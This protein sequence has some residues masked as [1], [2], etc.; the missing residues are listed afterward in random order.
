MENDKG[1]F[2]I[3]NIEPYW[4]IVIFEIIGRLWNRYTQ[5]TVNEVNNY[6]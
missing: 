3:D 2:T 4:H 6:T 1:I 5:L